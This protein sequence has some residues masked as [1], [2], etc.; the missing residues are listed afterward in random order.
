LDIFYLTL[1]KLQGGAMEIR[2]RG[3]RANATF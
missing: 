1:D 3:F 2:S